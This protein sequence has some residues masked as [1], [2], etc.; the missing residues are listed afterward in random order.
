MSPSTLKAISE[1]R[2]SGGARTGPRETL[3]IFPSDVKA[4]HDKMVSLVET[5]MTADGLQLTA[6]G[7]DEDEARIV[8]DLPKAKT[9]HV[10]ADGSRQRGT[11]GAARCVMLTRQAWYDNMS[12][13]RRTP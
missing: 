1:G 3:P 12:Y 5:M 9:P 10:W 6:H 7:P 2:H 8:E 13:Q 11:E 4:R